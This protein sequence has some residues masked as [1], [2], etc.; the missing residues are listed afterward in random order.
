MS[1]I[2]GRNRPNKCCWSVSAVVF[3][4]GKSPAP[5]TLAMSD[6]GSAKPV[7]LR[8]RRLIEE[9]SFEIAQMLDWE[10]PGCAVERAPQTDC[11]IYWPL[12]WH[13]GS[14]GHLTEA[15]P[16]SKEAQLR[17]MREQAAR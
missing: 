15:A 6:E 17:A 11:L 7:P 1:V 10:A 9:F 13:A 14:G 16:M 2:I 12:R 8:W 5:H 3:G 4:Y